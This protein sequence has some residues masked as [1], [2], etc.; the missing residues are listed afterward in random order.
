[1]QEGHRTLLRLRAVYIRV[2]IKLVFLRLSW[3]GA[4]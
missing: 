4:P 2:H 1:L 3:F